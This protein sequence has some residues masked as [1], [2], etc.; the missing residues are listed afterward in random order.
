MDRCIGH[1]DIT[2]IQ[3]RTALNTI[4]LIKKNHIILTLQFLMGKQPVALKEYVSS[5]G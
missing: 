1:R 4:Q 5:T 3:L 2:E